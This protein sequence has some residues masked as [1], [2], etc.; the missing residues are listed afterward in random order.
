[1]APAAR[2][3]SAG[4]VPLADIG[5][6]VLGVFGV[7][8]SLYDAEGGLTQSGGATAPATAGFTVAVTPIQVRP[9]TSTA[10]VRLSFRAVGDDM[11]DDSGRLGQNTRVTVI[12]DTGVTE[13]RYPAGT[14]AAPVE[15]EMGVDG[16]QTLY[17]F[18]EHSGQIVVVM[19]S[20]EVRPDGSVASLGPLPLILGA[21]AGVSGWNTS[22]TFT[23]ESTDEPVATFVFSRAFSTQAFAILIL[24]MSVVLAGMALVVGMLTKTR[25][26]T[27][28]ATMLSWSAALL[29]ALP[30]L[31]NFMPNA[32]PI[33]AAI[34]IYVFMW[35]MLAAVGAAVL[36]ILAWIERDRPRKDADHAA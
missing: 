25:R 11:L 23:D 26:R 21:A 16:D 9:V 3:R 30:A 17:P 34:D 15:V 31:R 5:A 36:V 2:S 22:A 27:V 35:V 19:D 24:L 7:V 33:G 32:P 8:T 12:T 20:Y 13:S 18:D 28:E 14:V 1:M 29:F 4:W 10:T 6:V